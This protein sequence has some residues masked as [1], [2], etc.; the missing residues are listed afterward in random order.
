MKIKNFDMKNKPSLLELAEL[1]EK[2][3]H[4][5]VLGNINGKLHVV[6]TKLGHIED[7]AICLKAQKAIETKLKES[8]N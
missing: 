5:V 8:Q 3:E 2:A 4:V 7:L 1:F 6:S